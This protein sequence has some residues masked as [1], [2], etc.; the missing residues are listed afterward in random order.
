MTKTSLY[1]SLTIILAHYLCMLDNDLGFLA[2]I[3]IFSSTISD[4]KN[5]HDNFM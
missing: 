3:M 4:L 5:T 1:E 2:C